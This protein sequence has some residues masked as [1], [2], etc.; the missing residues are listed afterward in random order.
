MVAK[1]RDRLGETLRQVEL[2]ETALQEVDKEQGPPAV[3]SKH[4]R[5]YRRMLA[6]LTPK[7]Q[8]LAIDAKGDEFRYGSRK[9]KLAQLLK[10]EGPRELLHGELRHPFEELGQLQSDVRQELMRIFEV[11]DER[12]AQKRLSGRSLEPRALP[13][14]NNDE[15][16]SRL[17]RELVVKL[18]LHRIAYETTISKANEAKAG[19]LHAG[20]GMTDEHHK[21]ALHQAMDELSSVH[22]EVGKKLSLLTVNNKGLSELLH[23]PG[24]EEVSRQ[25]DALASLQTSTE[26]ARTRLKGEILRW[27]MDSPVRRRSSDVRTAES[28]LELLNVPGTFGQQ[29]LA[30]RAFED[31]YPATSEVPRKPL[32]EA[33]AERKHRRLQRRTPPLENPPA[34]GSPLASFARMPERALSRHRQRADAVLIEVRQADAAMEDLHRRLHKKH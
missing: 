23:Q 29:R 22:K 21:K 8:R 18:Y 24:Y 17:A 14:V 9:N 26:K 20:E 11:L 25:H 28:S 7:L 31:E 12:K 19:L 32:P 15:V 34:A 13:V 30:K 5:V 4:E 2:A 16:I 1:H 33:D 6:D 27:Q 10:I 3:K